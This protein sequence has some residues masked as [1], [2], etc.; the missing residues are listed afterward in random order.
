MQ[1]LRSRRAGLRALLALCGM[2]FA[3]A[4]ATAQDQPYQM[5]G[6]VVDASS[7]EAVP[8]AQIVLRGTQLGTVS[9]DD[10][11]FQLAAPV[12]AGSYV[13]EFSSLG[14]R[15]ATRNIALGAQRFVDLGTIEL[16]TSAI[17]LEA[18]V[19]T[20]AGVVSERRR[21][22]NAV[23]SVRGEAVAEAPGAI[24]I[25]QALQGKVTGAVISENSG[26]PGG[27][28]SVRLRGTNSILGGAEPLYVIDGVLVDNNDAAL[29][30][31]GANATT[32]GAALSNRVAD[33]DPDDIESIEVLKGAAAAALYG[34]RANNGVIVITT[35]RGQQ[36][37]TRVRFKTA[38]S[39]SQTPDTY[40]LLDYPFAGAADVAFG[41]ADSIGQ[42]VE[43]FDIQDE[44]YRTGFGT[45]SQ[46]S[47]SGGQGGTLFYVSGGWDDEQGI[48]ESS[49]YQKLTGRLKLTQIMSE[50]LTA[51][52]NL[53][54]MQTE[55]AFVPEGE[56]GTGGVLTAAIF[57]PTSFD[58]SYDPVL[59]RFPISPLVGSGHSNP[60]D[61][62]ANW[63]APEDVLRFIGS[64]SAD[65]TPLP[66]EDLTIHY[67]FGI[68]DYRQETEFYRPP[69][70]LRPED[71]GYIT[72]PIRL[73][74]QM[75]HDLTADYG[76][77]LGGMFDTRTTLGF[78][79]TS[80]EAN[81]VVASATDLAPGQDIVG[82]ANQFASESV[83]EFRTVGGFIQE[84]LGFS[85]KLFLTAGLNVE[86]SSAFGADQ[87]WQLFPK[88]NTSYLL[89]QEPYFTESVVGDVFSTLRL[90]AA[91]GETGGQPP[92]A[93]LR[94]DNY[95]DVVYAGRPGYVPS[96]TLGNPD[97]KPERQ[98]EWELGFDAGLLDDRLEVVFSY[99][100]RL[101]TDLVL[102]VPQ[103]LSS[104]AEQQFQNVAEV[105]NKGFELA[106]NT[107]NLDR[108][109]FM[110]TSRLSLGHNENNVEE[111]L[112]DADTLQTRYLNVVVEGQPIGVFYGRGYERDASGDI[113]IDPATGLGARSSQFSILGDPN[114]DYVAAFGNT[115]HVGERLQFDVL[116]EG[117]FGNDVANF[118]RRITEYFGSDAV[119]ED[120]IRRAIERKNDPSLP[121]IQYALNAGRISNYE[122]YVEDGSFVKLRE[123]AIR[124]ELD[125]SWLGGFASEAAVRLAGRNL[126]TWTDYSGV[127]PEVNLFSSNTVARGV[128]FAT[129]PIPR[130]FIVGL[131][132]SL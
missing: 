40:D 99:Y 48:I 97:L 127:D 75:N 128:D 39:W 19:V 44:I 30:S 9:G 119:L 29:V 109:D 124:Y 55:A 24:A 7:G 115:L 49:D 123:V 11:G 105:S 130:T 116:L 59:G 41:P 54:V 47:V 106:L 81:V 125:P 64:A 50:Q 23:E 112:T 58:F 37:E 1:G 52:I 6:V 22:G 131:D 98:R 17:A 21:V 62:L 79:Y 74:R 53:S 32:S 72:N 10:G 104:G 15:T 28:V 89:H 121:P 38:L 107:V 84:Q 57:I 102:S 126:Y 63:R 12:D 27:G 3:A 92:G 77:M 61:V 73:S 20:G 65:W 110:W 91:Y 71:T 114:P 45:T 94:F 33:I 78:R 60:L 86:G 25:D 87:R 46:L 103:P 42:P 66:A 88:V 2:L 13:L 67:L 34:S 120:E 100:D 111:L 26:Q 43:R 118:T 117:R 68:D 101:T 96:V 95:F 70:S 129:T 69:F 16:E 122:E 80:N 36:G 4:P 14:Y 85:D 93:Y 35:K 90:R 83:S 5:R 108:G 82:G 113:V 51:N 18:L 8:G 132:L 31:L 56:Q 76:R